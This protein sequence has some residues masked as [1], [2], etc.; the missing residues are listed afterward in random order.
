MPPSKPRFLRALSLVVL[1]L[2]LSPAVAAPPATDPATVDALIAEGLEKWHAPGMAVAI[3][4]GDEVVYLKGHGVREAGKPDKVTPETVFGIGSLTKA[5]TATA[6]AQLVDEGK[7]SW[8]D[9]VRKHVPFFHLSD[10][11]ADRDVT[12]RDLLCHRTGLARHDVLYYRSSWDLEEVVRRMA[13][14]EPAHSFRSTYE[15]NN[16][17]Y[18]AL[19]FVFPNTAKTTWD[20]FVQKRLL[21]PLGM[22]DTVFTHEARLKH[23]AAIQHRLGG[24]DK[25]QIVPW[26]DEKQVRASG[27]IKSCARDLSKWLRLQLGDGTV[28]GKTLVSAKSLRET[29]TPQIVVPLSDEARLADTTQVSYGLGW[30]IHDY[31]GHG[32]VEHGGAVDGFRT[33]IV[34]VPKEHLG[35]VL[36]TNLEVGEVPAATGNV[37]LDHL[38]GLPKQDWH[39]WFAERVKEADAARKKREER[40]A[41]AHKTGTKPSRELAAYAGR[42]EDP[43]YG[44][45][46]VSSDG[47]PLMLSWSSF[48]G[49]LGHYHYDTFTVE[50]DRDG[51]ANRL[52]GE[53]ATFALGGDGEVATLHFLDRTFKRAKPKPGVP[54]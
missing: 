24:G 37:L 44:T 19:G 15:Y 22:K 6:L 52:T 29:H 23:E 25:V 32:I 35:L 50:K 13:Y 18:I 54:E 17:A 42:Y 39:G 36:L 1:L 40:Q 4:R 45:V 41:A 16:L 38:L 11:L 53:R 26:H 33:R 31:R 5:F 43:A 8:D 28:D 46:R 14:L 27:S 34:L 47:G 49:T 48:S 7:L 12:L 20:D 9:P 10:P 51:K 3:V 30:R 2:A 21:D